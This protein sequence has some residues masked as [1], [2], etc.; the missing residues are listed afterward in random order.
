[1][2]SGPTLAPTPSWPWEGDCVRLWFRS[3]LRW[4]TQVIPS[5]A[6]TKSLETMG[7]NKERTSLAGSGFWLIP[8]SAGASMRVL[9]ARMAAGLPWGNDKCQETED[10]C[11][12]S[13]RGPWMKDTEFN[14]G[15]ET[16]ATVVKE[17]LSKGKC[18]FWLMNIRYTPGA[19]GLK[20]SCLE[21]IYFFFIFSAP[22]SCL[23][24][25]QKKRAISALFFKYPLSSSFAT[26]INYSHG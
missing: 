11:K 3:I 8:G 25:C 12:L 5:G 7:C 21:W 9:K 10:K 1:M 16:T 18:L 22:F 15:K 6:V 13:E 23:W 4:H 17:T 20:G 26:V 24:F 14:L 2:E 19:Y